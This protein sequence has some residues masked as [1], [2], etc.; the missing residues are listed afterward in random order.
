[1]FCSVILTIKIKNRNIHWKLTYNESIGERDL[2]WYQPENPKSNGI[3]F[4]CREFTYILFIFQSWP[5]YAISYKIS[6]MYVD[7]L[8]G[9]VNFSVHK[10]KFH[11]VQKRSVL[12]EIFE[13]N[14]KRFNM[15]VESGCFYQKYSIIIVVSKILKFIDVSPN[16]KFRIFCNI[17]WIQYYWL[18]FFVIH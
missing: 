12:I 8:L 11:C 2:Y 5:V 18:D 13:N 1:M 15:F 17:L 14:E 16:F 10:R 4:P 3:L 6:I 9:Q 7:L